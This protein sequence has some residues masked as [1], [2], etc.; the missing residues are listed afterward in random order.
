MAQLKKLKG[1]K[2]PKYFWRTYAIKARRWIQKMKKK[3]KG[4]AK[5]THKKVKIHVK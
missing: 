1:K 5:K 3:A 2:E 4:G